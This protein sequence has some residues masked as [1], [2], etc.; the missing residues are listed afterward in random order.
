ML[1]LQTCVSVARGVLLAPPSTPRH[2]FCASACKRLDAQPTRRIII[3]GDAKALVGAAMAGDLLRVAARRGRRVG[4]VEA[5][6]A[7]VRDDARVVHV[8]AQVVPEALRGPVVARIDVDELVLVVAAPR[9]VEAHALTCAAER[10]ERPARRASVVAHRRHVADAADPRAQRAIRQDARLSV[11]HARHHADGGA[12]ALVH[13]HGARVG[14]LD[15]LVGRVDGERQRAVAVG[16][17]HAHRRPQEGAVAVL[18]A[19]HEHPLQG[20]VGAHVDG[21]KARVPIEE[22]VHLDDGRGRERV[23]VDVL[24]EAGLLR[25]RVR[26]RGHSDVAGWGRVVDPV[27]R[28]EH[29]AGRDEQARVRV[30]L[31][32]D[33]DA[34]DAREGAVVGGAAHRRDD[35]GDLVGLVVERHIARGDGEGERKQGADARHRGA[36]GRETQPPCATR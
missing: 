33:D 10:I 20:D 27:A 11:E 25:L 16:R 2:R 12:R 29:E 31:A 21:R 14:V 8:D 22:V 7:R 23:G 9:Q 34:H 24:A 28:G 4:H 26:A 18:V 15:E 6:A 3:G 35:D 32:R 13:A 30:G 5:L 17:D 19:A 1:P 36:P